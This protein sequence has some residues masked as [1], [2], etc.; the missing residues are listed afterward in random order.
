MDLDAYAAAH[1]AEWSRLARLSERRDLDGRE[2]DELIEG[3]QSGAAQLAAM[4]T[5]VGESVRGD[6]LSLA[7][8]R[9][10]LRFTGTGTNVFQRVT[11]FL[12]LQLPA[13]LYRIRWTSLAVTLA[14]VV[15]ATLYGM[16]VASDPR[17]LAT[18]G[19]DEQLRQYAEEDFL[20]YYEES[21]ELV[22]GAQVWTNN[23]WIA[24]QCVA[25][26][27]TGIWVPV[28]LWQNAVGVGGAGGVMASYDRLPDFFAGI[29]PHGQLELYSIFVA[30]A[31]GLMIFWSWVSPGA[32]TRAQALA[33]DGRAFFTL[34]IGLIIMLGISGIIEGA[35]TRQDWPHP[36]RIGI[37]TL[38]LAVVLL[39]QWVL[40][41]RAHRAGQTGDLE[42]FESGARRIAAD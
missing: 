28:V 25:F 10:R 41:R 20:G 19:S 11:E 3:Y 35:V 26:G 14:F 24:A 42:E 30:G 27:I 2:A 33:E 17:V 15:V 38:A 23:A 39:Y 9:A 29:L 13:A 1:D 37:G 16:W 6:R 5:T 12:A 40:G 31:T 32:R 36:V 8:S 22:F 7:L 21:S 34:V 4:K 18:F